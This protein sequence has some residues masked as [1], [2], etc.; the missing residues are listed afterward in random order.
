M[1][2]FT[3]G[4][5]LTSLAISIVCYFSTANIYFS[6]AVLIIYIGYYLVFQYSKLKKYFSLIQRVHSS[7][8]FINSFIITLSVKQ[9]YEEAFASGIKI[10][11]SQLKMYVDALTDLN[12]IEKPTYL[13]NYFK[14][15]VYEMFLNV[16]KIYQDQGG[17][18]LLMSDNLIRECTRTEK[19]LN[20]S[21]SVGI[22]HFI[23]FIILW[24]LSFIILLFM[25]FS[26]GEFYGKML[27]KKVIPI[28]ILFFFFIC[29]ASIH[30][31]MNAFFNL[32]IKEEICEWKILNT[33]LKS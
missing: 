24:C 16:L 10:K 26:T 25:R 7:C 6:L 12:S 23:E 29:L 8:F 22:R 18:I 21:S 14:L 9:S 33:R 30:F 31:F 28:L 11:D 13:K 19:L 20:E 1:V 2:G 32:S 4:F 5:I 27:S 17:D 3:I 15:S